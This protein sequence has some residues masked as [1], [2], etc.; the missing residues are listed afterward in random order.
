MQSLTFSAGPATRSNYARLQPMLSPCALVAKKMRSVEPLSPCLPNQWSMKI[1]THLLTLLAVATAFTASVSYAADSA[2][3]SDADL[4]TNATFMATASQANWTEVKLGDVAKSRTN[5]DDVKAYANEIVN[6]HKSAQE[7]LKK[8]MDAGKVDLPKDDRA[9][10]QAAVDELK[11]TTDAEFDRMFIK[12]M[13]VD[14]KS[15]VAAYEAFIAAT[16]S[17]ELKNYANITVEHL[18][19]HLAKAE[20]LAKAIGGI[21]DTK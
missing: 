5:R 20:T 10:Q 13:L 15:T 21:E 6:D 16:K 9:D 17:A 4:A 14:H 3:L 7:S 11:K 18:K 1:K 2:P 19:M 12:R 8:I